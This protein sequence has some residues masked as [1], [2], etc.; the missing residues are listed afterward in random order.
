VTAFLDTNVLIYAQSADA[1]AVAARDAILA[2]GVIS[3]QVLND[4]NGPVV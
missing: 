1:R 3:V 4:T 2:G